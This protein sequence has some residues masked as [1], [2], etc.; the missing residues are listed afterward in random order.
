[1]IEELRQKLASSIPPSFRIDSSMDY[2]DDGCAK[3]RGLTGKWAVYIEWHYE[4][5]PD[6]CWLETRGIDEEGR[7]GECPINSLHDVLVNLSIN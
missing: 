6:M 2:P 1:M 4:E 3:V 7:G 5:N